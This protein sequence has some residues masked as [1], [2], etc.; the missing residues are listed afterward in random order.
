MVTIDLGQAS[1]LLWAVLVSI[2][3]QYGMAAHPVW[4]RRCQ[5]GAIVISFMWSIGSILEGTY[6]KATVT[7]LMGLALGYMWFFHGSR[8][9][10]GLPLFHRR[11]TPGRV[12]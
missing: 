5:I 8:V 9:A 3:I 10:V 11:T 6:L 12:T 1:P 4:R 7:A 2:V